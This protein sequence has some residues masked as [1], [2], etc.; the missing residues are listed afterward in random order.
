MKKGVVGAVLADH[1]VSVAIV[2]LVLIDVMNFRTSRQALPDRSFDDG[3]MRVDS[4]T[5]ASRLT[6]LTHEAP[7][8]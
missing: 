1:K 7:E 5:V 4:P 3:V 2:F 6:V 8:S